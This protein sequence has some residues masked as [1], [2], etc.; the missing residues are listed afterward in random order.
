MV[1]S[2]IVSYAQNGEDILLWRALKHVGQGFYIDVGAQDPVEFSVTKAFYE[3]GWH[4]INIEPVS[5]WHER[6]LRDRPHDINLR[7]A[8]SS[9]PGKVQLFEVEDTGL[10]TVDPD[11]A[12]RHESE[13]YTLHERI[14]E[15]AT[16]D[17]ICA[18]NEV[19]TVHF[20][21]IDCEGAEKSVLE[22]ASFS[23]VR[24]WIVLVEATEPMSTKPTW[25]DWECLL[26]GRNYQFVFFDGL[27]R[28]Y[29][30]EEHKDLAPA[31][32]APVNVFDVMDGV[33]RIAEIKAQERI[34]R[35]Q[36]E[37][38]G[39]R[40]AATVSALRA[41]LAAAN[42]Q[43]EAVARDRDK[44]AAERDGF[45]SERDQIA[46]ERASLRI[47]CD[48]SAAELSRLMVEHDRTAAKR[49]EVLAE[50]DALAMERDAVVAERD[51]LRIRHSAAQCDAAVLQAEL[52]RLQASNADLLSSH[53]WRLTAPLRGCS[54]AARAGYRRLRRVIYL[55]LRPFAHSARPM[56]HRLAARPV[57]RRT[58][59][60]VFG[61]HSRLVNTARLFLFGSSVAPPPVEDA[62]SAEA[63][64]KEDA[65]LPVAAPVIGDA[66]ST[67][68]APE[69]DTSLSARGREMLSMLRERGMNAKGES[70]RAR[71]T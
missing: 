36:G 27:N 65:S 4:G 71:H 14:V 26:T 35:L 3:L 47:E 58:I 46:A 24:P 70:Q 51:D 31:F 19:G 30:A 13:G 69:E 54:R 40:G 28:F 42:A 9:Q 17:Q 22:G 49:D 48:K 32:D 68:T 38:E 62:T 59:V 66:T 41:E 29:L 39:L 23:R 44:I 67:E 8:V 5:Q 53:S 18:D 7:L 56:M 20:L 43:R 37:V 60:S 1:Q 16:L 55:L 57:A 45:A 34:D 6:L 21:K 64:P 33:R 10:S 63:V 12:H 61:K 50:R 52:T 15:C 11:V 25:R 2:P